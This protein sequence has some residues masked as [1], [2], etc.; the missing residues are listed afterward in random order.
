M[1]AWCSKCP[2][3]PAARKCCFCVPVRRGIIIFGYVN[4]IVWMLMFPMLVYM[5][6]ERAAGGGGVVDTGE[7]GEGSEGAGPL[8]LPLTTA[9]VL[10]DA[11]L[12]VV[13]LVGAHQKRRLMLTTYVWGGATVQLVMLLL[14]LVYLDA[15]HPLLNAVFLPFIG[16]NM[17]LLYLVWSLT[18]VLRARDAAPAQLLPTLPPPAP[19]RNR[20][21]RYVM[22]APAEPPTSEE[23]KP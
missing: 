10:L 12:T 4:L 20:E 21:W 11:A 8:Q 14:D 5:L 1:W 17:Y 13:L 19:H 6:A 22:H 23:H 9:C 15:R 2:R 18:E 3:L 7:T 16:L